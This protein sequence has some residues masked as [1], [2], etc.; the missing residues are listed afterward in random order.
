MSIV[1]VDIGDLKVSADADDVI[2]TYALG[3]CIAIMVH[4]PVRVAGGMIHY[5]LPLSGTS[6]EK[7]RDKPAM[8]ADTGI[9]E[10]FHA[11]YGLGCR[12][13]DLVVKVA[14]GGALYDDN[15]VFRI[16]EKNYAVL[17]AILKRAGVAISAEDVGGARSRT[18]RLHVA[19]GRCTV[20]CKGEEV[21]L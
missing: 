12:K 8:F 18:A 3:S 14:G 10:L 16:G 5:M 21:A 13:S 7:A 19:T 4:D 6:P 20:S 1:T 9:P 17:R 2:V 15:G 11:M